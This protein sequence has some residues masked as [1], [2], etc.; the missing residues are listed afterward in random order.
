MQYLTIGTNLHHFYYLVVVV[1]YK[2]GMLQK[3]YLFTMKQL[4]TRKN[5]VTGHLLLLGCGHSEHF[6]LTEVEIEK[7]YYTLV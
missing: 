2:N 7:V 4:L 5:G 3:F 6:I 1:T